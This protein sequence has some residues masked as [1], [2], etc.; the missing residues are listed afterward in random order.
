MKE[1]GRARRRGGSCPAA[2]LTYYFKTSLR[3][4]PFGVRLRALSWFG[5]PVIAF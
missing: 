3:A 4:L 2:P 1:V 5:A